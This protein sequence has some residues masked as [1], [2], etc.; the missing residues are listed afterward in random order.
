MQFEDV[1]AQLEAW[2]SEAFRKIYA[3]QGAGD[4]QFGV[5]MGQL[6]G[7]AKKLKTDHALAMRL[8]ATGNADAMILATMLM[9]SDQLSEREVEE[10]VKAISHYRLIDELTYNAVAKMPFADSLRERWVHSPEEMIG[11]AGWNLVTARVLNKKTADLVIPNILDQIE[12]EMAAAPKRKQD[13][14]NRS[15]VEI[16]TRLPEYTQQCIAIGEKLGRLDDTPV[17][18]GC[19]SSYAPEWIAAVLKRGQ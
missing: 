5:G 15:L 10:M 4:H 1:Y 13:S 8:W 9:A 17:A 12:A 7:L 18:K 11:R 3:R 19:T 14:M 16:G 2:G 6:R